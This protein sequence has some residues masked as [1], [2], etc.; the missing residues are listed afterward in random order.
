MQHRRMASDCRLVLHAHV[1][2]RSEQVREPNTPKEEAQNV[3]S[4]TKKVRQQ[5]ELVVQR[6]S[7]M[8]C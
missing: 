6:Q 7:S 3:A 5:H 4:K 2:A 8:L 1:A